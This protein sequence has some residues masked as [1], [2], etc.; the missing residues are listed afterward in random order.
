MADALIRFDV[1]LTPDGQV[2]AVRAVDQLGQR[3]QQAGRKFGQELEGGVQNALRAW[4]RALATG[5][6]VAAI[7]HTIGAII[8]AA[9]QRA[10]QRLQAWEREQE[11]WTK[12]NDRWRSEALRAQMSAGYL[13]LLGVPDPIIPDLLRA[14]DALRAAGRGEEAAGLAGVAR[15]FVRQGLSGRALQE[16]LRT[17]IED[18]Q[19][20]GYLPG[21]M[22][23]YQSLAGV[24]APAR[25]RDLTT[26]VLAAQAR[27]GDDIGEQL[28]KALRARELTLDDRGLARTTNPALHDLVARVN[29][30][31][32][33]SMQAWTL[34]PWWG[35][36]TRATA[37]IEL[38][39]ARDRGLDLADPGN[40]PGRPDPAGRPSD[41]PNL[42][43]YAAAA[44]ESPMVQGMLG[45]L[46]VRIVEKLLGKMLE[47]S[48][49]PG[50]PPIPTPTGPAGASGGANTAP[51]GPSKTPWWSWLLG[52]G[53]A[54]AVA[55][56]AGVVAAPLTTAGVMDLLVRAGVQPGSDTPGQ[57]AARAMIVQ[58][59]AAVAPGAAAGHTLDLWQ[60]IASL[61]AI[62]TNTR[63][64]ANAVAQPGAPAP[65][66]VIQ[67][68]G[69]TR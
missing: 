12:E 20:R 40:L 58:Q 25:L 56:G 29:A 32:G 9:T 10:Q 4:K 66:P 17:A 16:A 38:R 11:R 44:L 37:A 53:A 3:A 23:T 45:V 69:G 68:E 8:D 2:K 60:A 7:G 36:F 64:I 67:G 59:A 28:V 5:A 47:A 27:L 41:R 22:E 51:K 65:L 43:D 54:R 19:A 49:K 30:I 39:E 1:A 33:L 48:G 6:T 18:V 34:P 15:A 31:G 52:L 50:V 26:A 21:F 46:A 42:E 13:R 62:E 61:R 35:T 14:G 57:A 55:G 63:H 24:V